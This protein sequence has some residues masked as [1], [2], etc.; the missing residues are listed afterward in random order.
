MP[1]ILTVEVRCNLINDRLFNLII[2][3]ELIKVATDA[4]GKQV[5][6]ARDLYKFLEATERFSNWMERNLQYGFDE[7]VDYVG[8][9][10]IN[11]LANQ[12]LDDFALTLNCAKEIAMIQ[13]SDKGKQAR[14]YFI[15]CEKKLTELA[16]PSYQIE[17]ELMR[18]E[19]WIREKK[20]HLLE[21]ENKDNKIKILEPKAE[22]YDTVANTDT[23]F[24]FAQAAKMMGLKFGNI[25]L[26]SKL[27]DRKILDKEN[28]PYQQYVN[29]GYF[30]LKQKTYVM[31]TGTRVHSQ[32]RVTEKGL[33]WLISNKQQL[34]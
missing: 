7:N 1:V 27:R 9:K 11:T 31:K 21:L 3:E 10:Q 25:T 23:T 14:Q 16:L 4:N 20:Q 12:E 30:E 15:E 33:K 22:F 5:V 17:D 8:C 19:A 18:A 13:R 28:V 29:A 24:D 6:S 26:F 32:A 2:M 34:Q